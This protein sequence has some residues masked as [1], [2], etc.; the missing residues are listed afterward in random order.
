[1]RG[2]Q[3]AACAFVTAFTFV[4]PLCAEP[5]TTARPGAA[6]CAG[7]RTSGICARRAGS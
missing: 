2:L 6:P 3:L 7:A 4:E 1:M 5:G